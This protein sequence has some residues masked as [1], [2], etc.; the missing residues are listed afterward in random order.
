MRWE[1]R[2]A[3]IA[4]VF[5]FVAAAALAQP[6]TVINTNDS[7]AGSLRQAITDANAHGGADVINFAIPGGG[8]HT[9]SPASAL[10]VITDAVTIDGTTQSGSSVNTN[11]FGQGLNTILTV[12]IDALDRTIVLARN[13]HVGPV[14]VSGFNIDDDAVRDSSSADNDFWVRPVGVSRMNTAAACF[15]KI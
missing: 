2:Y 14:N 11:A 15:K 9:I 6:Y 5:A 12:E 1:L 13:A 4:L 10:P 7:G 8:L 3:L